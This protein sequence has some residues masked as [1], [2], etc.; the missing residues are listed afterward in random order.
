MYDLYPKQTGKEWN[1][2]TGGNGQDN[3][4]NESFEQQRTWGCWRTLVLMSAVLALTVLDIVHLLRQFIVDE[5][6]ICAVDDPL[7][8]VLFTDRET[9]LS[10]R[11]RVT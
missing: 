6:F 8:G 2:Y 7:D 11:S 1:G 9:Q 4:A 3:G 10:E 5:K